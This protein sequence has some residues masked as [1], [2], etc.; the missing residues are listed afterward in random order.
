MRVRIVLKGDVA[1]KV[2]IL[3]RHKGSTKPKATKAT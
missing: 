1:E 2:S 3:P